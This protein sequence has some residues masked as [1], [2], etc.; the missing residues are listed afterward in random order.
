MNDNYKKILGDKAIY[1]YDEKGLL[2]ILRNFRKDDY[3]NVDINC[4]KDYSPQY[5]ITIFNNIFC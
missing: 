2:E 1:Y 4:Y 3:K 5:V